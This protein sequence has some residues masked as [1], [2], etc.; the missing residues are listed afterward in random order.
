VAKLPSSSKSIAKSGSAKA[1]AAAPIQVIL[2]EDGKP[3][4]LARIIFARRSVAFGFAV[5]GAVLGVLAGG[6]HWPAPPANLTESIALTIWMGASIGST[7][8]DPL[9]AVST[10]VLGTVVGGSLGFTIG[11]PMKRILASWILGGL[12]LA[13]GLFSTG[14]AA[15]ALLGWL[16][17]YTIGLRGPIK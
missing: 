16:F 11:L 12:A 15:I 10:C 7:I 6:S 4:D 13:I 14:N 17:G 3:L 5:V 9:N 8:V 2:N 1:V